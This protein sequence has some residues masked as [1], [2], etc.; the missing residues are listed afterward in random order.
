MAK[1]MRR[2][3]DA[4]R[5]TYLGKQNSRVIRC[6]NHEILHNLAGCLEVARMALNGA[7]TPTLP[8]SGGG[9]KAGS[10]EE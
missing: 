7:P 10:H 9:G 2:T 4:A 6:W 8:R 3:K 5:M 1:P